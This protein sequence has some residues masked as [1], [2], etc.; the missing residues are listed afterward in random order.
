MAGGE[1]VVVS[2]VVVQQRHPEG[3]IGEPEG[4]VLGVDVD[5]PFR[6]GLQD[7]Q[8]DGL[9]IDEAPGPARPVQGAADDEGV[10]LLEVIVPK[11]GLQGDVGAHGKLGLHHAGI[12]AGTHQRSV[13]LSAQDKAQ[14]AE[15]DGLAGSGLSGYNDETLRKIDFQR[16]YQYVVPDVEGAEHYSSPLISMGFALCALR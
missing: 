14:G 9:V 15:E 3:R 8:G 4:L 5:E 2:G 10:A 16:V 11:E 12:P 1:T 13:R 6:K 7:R